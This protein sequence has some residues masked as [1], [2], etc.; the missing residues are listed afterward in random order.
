L[1]ANSTEKRANLFNICANLTDLCRN[2]FEMQFN[3]SKLTIKKDLPGWNLM[4]YYNG[5]PAVVNYS[6][7]NNVL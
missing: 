5:C 7:K 2:H 1:C 6:F 4:P 3:Y